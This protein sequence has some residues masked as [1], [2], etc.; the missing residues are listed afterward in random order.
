MALRFAV[1][2]AVLSLMACNT[3]RL[4]HVPPTANAPGV[5]ELMPDPD[6]VFKSGRFSPD[7]GQIA[8]HA[9]IGGTR[10]VVGVMNRDGTDLKQLTD[11][12]ST[13]TSVAWAPDG[14][15]I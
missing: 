15:F 2:V 14:T 12:H 1:V 13:T 8:F 9:L 7:G 6:Q 4:V 3:S 11:S 5:D 10:D